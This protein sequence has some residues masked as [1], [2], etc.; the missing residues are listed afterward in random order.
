MHTEHLQ[1]VAPVRVLAGW[2]VSIAVASMAVF[3]FIALG[4]MTGESARDASWAM[5]A[6]AVGFLAG[7]WFTGFRA[8]EAPILHGIG[9]GLTSLVAWVALNALVLLFGAGEWTGLTPA[10]TLAVLLTQVLAAVVGCWAGSRAA[11]RRAAE[12][13]TSPETG[14]RGREED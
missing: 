5:V 12:V 4:L 13:A 9:L 14:V 7:G 10:A 8:M 3:G 1:N 6:V 2:L 11:R